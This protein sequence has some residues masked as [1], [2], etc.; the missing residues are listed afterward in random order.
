MIVEI[1]DH[2]IDT[3]E[4]SHVVRRVDRQYLGLVCHMK[5]GEYI[6]LVPLIYRLHSSYEKDRSDMKNLVKIYD[7]FKVLLDVKPLEI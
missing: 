2:I 1:E 3:S 5:N 4:I 7:A 6:T